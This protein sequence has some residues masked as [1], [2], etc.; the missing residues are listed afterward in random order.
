MYEISIG[1]WSSEMNHKKA[2]LL[3]RH[4]GASSAVT[5]SL[6][7]FMTG[8]FCFTVNCKSPMIHKLSREN[9]VWR[10][11]IL[12]SVYTTMYP[13]TEIVHS[14]TDLPGAWISSVTCPKSR[15]F[16]QQQEVNSKSL[17]HHLACYCCCYYYMAHLVQWKN[18]LPDC[19]VN[20]TV[21]AAVVLFFLSFFLIFIFLSFSIGTD[22]LE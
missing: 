5:L 18:P 22:Y 13:S 19:G 21:C 10:I 9:V 1:V 15:T 17:L 4:A 2:H 6:Q 14:G 11:D 16:R 7:L 12:N 3:V 8:H 20:T